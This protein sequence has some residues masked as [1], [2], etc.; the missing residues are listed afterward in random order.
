MAE[1]Q[2][3]AGFVAAMD[4]CWIERRFDD[5]AD[6]L[7]PDVVL[8]APG[9]AARL[10]GRDAAIASYCDFM[11]SCVL[12]RWETTEP[13]I[14]ERGATA[15]IEYG[16]SMAWDADGQSFAETGR[17]VLVLANRDAAWRVV[18]RTQI[19]A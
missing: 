8:V 5:L 19:P 17:E 2:D 11:A 13:V 6:Y 16:W 1:D 7:A 3:L 4:R 10:D 18:W 9:G 14:T 12:K 15:I